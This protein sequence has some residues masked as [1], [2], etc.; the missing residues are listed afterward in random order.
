MFLRFRVWLQSMLREV[1]FVVYEQAHHRGGAATEICVN[2]TGRVQEMCAA[3]KIEFST[4]HSGTLKKWACGGGKADKEQMKEMAAHYIGRPAVD[5]NEAD[6][7]LMAIWA[8]AEYGGGAHG[9]K[10]N[11]G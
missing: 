10:T 1:D 8:E 6:A 3:K 5:D 2:L 4:V 9:E 7:V 11:A